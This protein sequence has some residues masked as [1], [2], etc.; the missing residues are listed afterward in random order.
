MRPRFLPR[1][2]LSA[3]VLTISP[4]EETIVVE[5]E[6]LT[7]CS[8]V[9]I[10]GEGPIYRCG[11]RGIHRVVPWAGLSP[12]QEA[13]IRQ[14]HRE[15]LVQAICGAR[16]V[17]GSVF[18]ANKDGVIVQVD[19]EALAVEMV[20]GYHRGARVIGSG[21]VMISDLPMDIP[22]S[23]GDP[24]RVIAY[25]RGTYAFDMAIARTDIEHLTVA[26]PEWFR[27]RE[28]KNGAGQSMKARLLGIS[29]GRVLFESEDGARFLYDLARLDP[30]SQREAAAIHEKLKKFPV[31]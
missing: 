22:R 29:S 17:D 6:K 19:P 24:I 7:D 16:Y 18:H 28:W 8:L 3:M 5:G 21:L 2:I 11:D 26:K 4:G 30:A 13:L 10:S 14:R 12:E 27:F 23:T 20:E 1:A 15:A 9:E 25:F 31:P